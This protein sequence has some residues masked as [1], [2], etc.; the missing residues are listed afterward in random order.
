[1]LTIFFIYIQSRVFRTFPQK[2]SNFREKQLCKLQ[3]REGP[4]DFN[5]AGLQKRNFN[6]NQYPY[7]R[8][9]N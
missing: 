3:Q 5:Q 1:M 8:S 9:D 6:T 2:F 4:P 7:H